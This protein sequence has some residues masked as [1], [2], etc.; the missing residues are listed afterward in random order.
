MSL[1][2]LF[3]K[4][5]SFV[6]QGAVKVQIRLHKGKCIT[7]NQ[8]TATGNDQDSPD[9]KDTGINNE[10]YLES[11]GMHTQSTYWGEKYPEKLTWNGEKTGK[12]IENDWGNAGKH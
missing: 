5:Q 11:T 7:L 3:N 1:T 6:E 12:K 9:W 8:G 10:E 4:P 2:G